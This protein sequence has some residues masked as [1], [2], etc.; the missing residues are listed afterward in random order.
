MSEPVVPATASVETVPP[1]APAAPAAPE[2]APTASPPA[3]PSGPS[4]AERKARTK[5]KAAGMVMLI[6]GGFFLVNGVFAI[7]FAS[8]YATSPGGT[9]AVRA[10][11]WAGATVTLAYAQGNATV[12]TVDAAGNATLTA[13]YAAFTL[14][15]TRGNDTL[16]RG[17]LVPAG[18]GFAT[19]LGEDATATFI[20]YPEDALRNLTLIATAIAA[21]IFLGGLAAFRRSAHNMAMAGSVTYL[22][23]G[24]YLAYITLSLFG[25]MFLATAALCL[26]FIHRNRAHITPGWAFWRRA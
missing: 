5:V 26:W 12:A 2:G 20:G 7:A 15:A 9:V 8:D 22:A 10:P 17:G 1:V 3:A 13:T 23:A 24:A 11:S 18:A 25:V 4:D 14:T 6:L 16:Q 19:K 21:I